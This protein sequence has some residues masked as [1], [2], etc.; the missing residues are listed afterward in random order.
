MIG[1]GE[2]QRS[3][4]VS[5]L[6][7]GERLD[8]ALRA[9]RGKDGSLEGTV[10]SDELP[11]AGAVVLGGEGEFEHGGDYNLALQDIA[12]WK[13]IGL[14]LQILL[15]RTRYITRRFIPVHTDGKNSSTSA[16]V[17]RGDFELEH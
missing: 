14:I 2:H 17:C 1:V 10:R 12:R 6:R 16:V 5:Y 11:C 13:T 4:Q 8:S 7:R 15:K 9:D 3:A